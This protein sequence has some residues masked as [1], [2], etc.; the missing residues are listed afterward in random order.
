[1][2]LASSSLLLGLVLMSGMV[3]ADVPVSERARAL[4]RDGVA[5]LKAAKGPEYAEAYEDFKA[6]YADS[7]SSKI[8]GNLGLC[9][10]KL[11]RDGEAIAFYRR[12]L[13][14]AGAKSPAERKAIQKDLAELERR[15]AYVT[16]TVEPSDVTITDRRLPASGAPI[17]NSYV[18]E[19]GRIELGLR[20]G[21]HRITIEAP[22]RATETLDLEL[23]PGSRQERAVTLASTEDASPAPM[24][25]PE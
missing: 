5:H 9:A 23:A 17:I 21:R 6:A 15:V 14:E 8:L 18:A 22:D 13:D 1:M 16:L 19:G 4:F 24:A 3:R 12:Y 25:I 2:R 10:T 20:N 7:P 11:E